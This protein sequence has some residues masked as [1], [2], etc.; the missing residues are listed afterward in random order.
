MLPMSTPRLAWPSTVKLS[1][2]ATHGRICPSQA[3]ANGGWRALAS[4]ILQRTRVGVCLRGKA[5]SR[6]RWK[7]G[8]HSPLSPR[9]DVL[10]RVISHRTLPP[11][12]CV[13]RCAPEVFCVGEFSCSATLINILCRAL[14]RKPRFS[15]RARARPRARPPL[16]GSCA[17]PLSLSSKS[18]SNLWARSLHMTV[19]TIAHNKSEVIHTENK[20]AK[21]KELMASIHAP[22][23]DS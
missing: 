18:H 9:R 20:R 16:V 10:G 4:P 6:G 22:I 3:A 1:G 8:G 2:A 5:G 21:E 23:R 7:R 11:S 13:I 15:M 14:A 17:A 12:T 19:D